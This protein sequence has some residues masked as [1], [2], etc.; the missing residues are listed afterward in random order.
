VTYTIAASGGCGEVQ[1]TAAV[2]IGSSAILVTSPANL[3]VIYP[4]NARFGVKATGSGL[5]YQWQVNTGS[6]FTDIT[7][8]GVYSGSGTDTLKLLS[9]AVSMTGYRYRAIVTG[10]C[11]DAAVSEAGTLTVLLKEFE[12]IIT[13]EGIDKMYDGN[14]Q[15][16]VNLKDN[17]QAGDIIT[18]NYASATFDTKDAGSGKTVLVSGITVSGPDAGKY[19]FNTSTTTTAAITPKPVTV[20][21]D[22]GLTKVYGAAD[23]LFTY[24]SSPEI[25]AGDLFTGS[26]TRVPGENPGLY[27]ILRGTLSLGNNYL[28]TYQSND[29]EITY[30]TL[31]NVMVN[32]GQ[33][34]VY[35]EAD[36]KLAY[37]YYPP[38]EEGDFFTGELSRLPGENIGD[39]LVVRGTLWISP[40][41][42][43]IVS[44]S[45]LTI[46]PKPISVMAVADTKVYDGTIASDGAPAI[47]PDLAFDD[48]SLFIQTY[49]NKNTGTQKTLS[50]SGRVDDGN[51]G[52]NYTVTFVAVDLGIITPKPITGMI[53]AASKVYD[54]TVSATIIDR[55]LDGVIGSDIVSY[56]GGTATFDTPDVGLN[57]TV[58]GTGFRLSG[59]DS[60]NYTVNDTA[61][62][63]ADITVLE[64]GTSLSVNASTFSHYTDLITLTAT[65]Y[66]GAPLANGLPAA[67]SATFAI[68]GR[69]IMDNNGNENIPLVISG[70]D[71]V[72]SITVAI[73]ETTNIGS[74]TSGTKEVTALFN[75]VNINYNV[76]PNPARATFDFTPGF[77]VRVYPNPS[78][79]QLNFKLSVDVGRGESVTL[80]LYSPNGQL[81]IRVF[82]GFIAVGESKTI[83]FESRLAQGIYLYRAT[84]GNETKVG[85]VIIIGVY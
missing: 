76:T 33:T 24:S 84:A 50:P 25:I 31:I 72:A 11:G 36:P 83:K 34:K 53:T 81:V 62:A 75:E 64:A 7:D 80:D 39:Y 78:P 74:M 16:A 37:T 85:N 5:T 14:T 42:A 73:L 68:E 49:D 19:E 23:P 54:G 55:T 44:T 79:G 32:A 28:M 38:L 21:A 43:I 4:A 51:E 45:Y 3:T 65:I 71:L 61:Y 35:G 2:T 13:A 6:G 70:P 29:F 47:S 56:V 15:A 9:P 58:T 67:K 77:D 63:K 57:K 30:K 8:G 46:T 40:K 20:T 26:L 17:H 22:K 18:I 52:K 66:G 69:V 60:G 1:A 41:Y 12:L 10:T 48:Q 82:E 59:I 27:A